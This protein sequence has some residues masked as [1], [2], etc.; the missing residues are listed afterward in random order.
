MRVFLVQAGHGGYRSSCLLQN[1]WLGGCTPLDSSVSRPLS[2]ASGQALRYSSPQTTC[3]FILLA[4]FCVGLACV[5]VRLACFL[6]GAG[7]LSLGADVHFCAALCMAGP[8]LVRRS[9]GA[10]EAR[11]QAAPQVS[12]GEDLQVKGEG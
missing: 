2:L 10:R 4:C 5:T 6:C 8:G 3:F 9:S 11:V 12:S 7:M 1:G